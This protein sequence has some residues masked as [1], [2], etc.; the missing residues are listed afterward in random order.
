MKQFLGIISAIIVLGIGCG[1]HSDFAEMK[2]SGTL[3]LTEHALGAKAAGRLITVNVDEGQM[4][5]QGQQLATMDR[6]QQNARDYQRIEKLFKQ[7]G[8]TQ[9]DLEHAALAMEDQQ[10]VAPIDGVVLVKV[11]E[12]G[13]VVAA[14]LPVVVIGDRQSLWVKIYVPEGQVNKIKMGQAARLSFDGLKETFRGQ[15]SFIAS[16][17]EFTPRNVQTAEERITQTFAVKVTL[18]DA[19]QYLRPGVAV[20]VSIETKG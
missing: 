14:G 1:Y 12:V 8:A 16:Q 13:E 9:Q 19:P 15:V 3:E 17:A 11:H 4:V 7:G 10:I 18:K 20:D 6:Y 5:K 2:F